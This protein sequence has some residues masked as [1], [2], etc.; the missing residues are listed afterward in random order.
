[1]VAFLL[2]AMHATLVPVFCITLPGLTQMLDTGTPQLQDWMSEEYSCLM[3]HFLKLA[4][5]PCSWTFIHHLREQIC[6]EFTIHDQFREKA[7]QV[8]LAQLGPHWELFLYLC[9]GTRVPWGL[10]AGDALALEGYGRRLSLP[11]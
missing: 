8:E 9:G 11:P 10:F 7:Q 1:M 2:P 3:W 6:S 5:I 4:G